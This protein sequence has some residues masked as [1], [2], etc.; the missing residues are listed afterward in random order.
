MR[1]TTFV[2]V[3]LISMAVPAVAQEWTEYHSVRDGFKVDFPGEPTVTETTWKSEHGFML[4]ERIYTVDKGRERYS[5]SVMD[6]RGIEPMGLERAKLCPPGSEPCLGSDLAGIGYWKHE[7]RGAVANAMLRLMQRNVR[8][9]DFFWT[10]LDLV[11]G[12]Q[13]QMINN[14]DQSPAFAFVAMHDNRLYV[15]EGFVPKGYPAP[16]LFQTSMGWLDKDGNAIRYQTLYANEFHGMGIYP[17]PP[18]GGGG[19]AGRGPGGGGQGQG[20]GRGRRGGGA[21]NPQ[22]P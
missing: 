11:E 1:V 5:V 16:A 9:T 18:Y 6:Y 12:F 19:G 3:L 22:Q 21:G 17:P 13:L 20:G 15:V 7:I 14:A 4:P 8:V 10:Q 2:L